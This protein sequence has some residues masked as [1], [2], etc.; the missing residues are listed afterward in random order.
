MRPKL[1]S[2]SMIV[3]LLAIS[4][5]LAFLASPVGMIL[6]AEAASSST[7]TSNISQGDFTLFSQDYTTSSSIPSNVFVS[8][9]TYPEISN[10]TLS[11]DN[12]R[13]ALDFG[14]ARDQV[15]SF[16]IGG[17]TP[18]D[19]TTY[20]LE[21]SLQRSNGGS[22]SYIEFPGG[23]FIYQI[24]YDGTRLIRSEDGSISMNLGLVSD[25]RIAI[26]IILDTSLDTFRVKYSASQFID[27]PWSD[28]RQ[29]VPYDTFTGGFLAFETYVNHYDTKVDTFIYKLTQTTPRS[30]ITSLGAKNLTAFGLDHGGP[31]T[32]VQNGVAAVTNVGGKGTLWMDVGYGFM[33][34]NTQLAYYQDLINNHGWV[35]GIHFSKILTDMTMSDA[36]ALMQSEYN[37]LTAR[38]G[39]AP[40]T[41]CCLTN[42][43]NM[44]LVSWAYTHL[45]MLD[46]NFDFGTGAIPNVGNL[47]SD[48]M[49]WWS[50]AA[51][52][53][54][55]MPT[56]VHETDITPPGPY[57]LSLADFK[58]WVNAY[59]ASGIQI[60]SFSDWYLTN[61]NAGDG[62]ATNIVANDQTATFTMSTNGA[63]CYVN[64]NYHA[65]A[66]TVVTDQGAGSVPYTVQSDGSISFW[67]QNGHTYSIGQPVTQQYQLTVIS[68]QG[69]PSPAVGTYS[70]LTGTTVSAS[71]TSPVVSGG[72]SYACTGFTGTGSAPSGTGTSTS[73]TI[74][75]TSTLTWNWVKS[76]AQAPTISNTVPASASSTVYTKGT[77]YT[78]T[79]SAMYTDN[80]AVTSVKITLDG[81][82]V[83]SAW[84]ASLTGFSNSTALSVNS[85][86]VVLT[87]S[88]AAGNQA[89]QTWTVN[90]KKDTTAPTISGYVN[91][92]RLRLGATI[93]ITITD[94][95][96]GVNMN[97]LKVLIDNVD[98]T[99]KVTKN[100]KGFVI[101]ASQLIRGTHTISVSVND[102]VNNTGSAKWTVIVR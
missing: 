91:N 93:T 55:V 56:F 77:T 1:A 95:Q 75:A 30:Y 6:S 96:S 61:L 79:F 46:R 97:T 27:I 38:M 50:K 14:V 84:K 24:Y 74:S 71:V 33:T 9:P 39:V 58:K 99:S 3:R 85:H 17:L 43:E 49:T 100:S 76:D 62:Q 21:M 34:D 8:L 86:T 16:F 35:L 53:G 63:R 68:A 54:L 11:Y 52:A 32:G 70:Y 65:T 94:T 80:I 18:M 47:W 81:T 19:Q 83:T 2:R 44:T 66:L 87:V 98:V 45:G 48:T 12:T 102:T 10:A 101:P 5:A 89:T 15:G 13:K 37:Q 57:S 92:Q 31:L 82:D 28:D 60:T 59:T 40:T 64:V 41:W 78:Q 26:D 25:N 22:Q 20:H 51:T 67:T 73:F 36:T 69:S 88:D 42:A 23:S 90:V 4:V 72:F 29:S 7:I